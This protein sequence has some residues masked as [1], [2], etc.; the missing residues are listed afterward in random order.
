MTDMVMRPA[1]QPAGVGAGVAS[2]LR[3]RAAWHL[4]HRV[5][6]IDAEFSALE[7]HL[8][9]LVADREAQTTEDT[10]PWVLDH[11]D[12]EWTSSGA[13]GQSAFGRRAHRTPLLTAEQEVVLARS[14]EAGAFAQQRLDSGVELRR[15]ERRGLEHVV[16]TAD[17][18]RERMI[19]A[20]VRLVTSIARKALPRVGHGMQF[21]DVQQA[22]LI[23]LMRAVDKF[24]H[25]LGHKFSTYATWW[26]KQSISRAIDDEV[27]VVRIPVHALESAR[28][29]DTTRRR[30][31]LTWQESLAD[32]GRLGVDVTRDDV[33]RA[34]A[35]LRPCLSLNQVGTELDVVDD[36]PGLDPIEQCIDRLDDEA[37]VHDLLESLVELPGLGTRAVTVLQ[38]RH[39]LTGQPPM[40]LDEIGKRFGVTRERIRQIEKKA[41]DA[42]RERVE[43]R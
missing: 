17:E 23:G 13:V 19:L 22:G 4:S 36:D 37:D 1:E 3:P 38:L 9:E 18:A 39:G 2:R 6:D 21:D 31:G 41:L 15:T 8:A 27:R 11:R 29:V 7:A 42:L 35:H 10:T 34:R 14:I 32:P 20:N 12:D 40:T 26:I 28:R 25:T 16:R 30:E 33:A 43:T 24:D 5:T